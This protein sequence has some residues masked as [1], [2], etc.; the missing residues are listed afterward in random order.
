MPSVTRL[1]ASAPYA[2]PMGMLNR[3]FLTGN[4]PLELCVQYSHDSWLVVV[5]Y[6]VS[7]FAAY[8]AFHLIARVRATASG[9]ARFLWLATAGVSMGLG[10][11]AMHFIAMLAVEIPIQVRFDLPVTALSAGFAVVASTLAFHFVARDKPRAIELGIAGAVLGSG[12]G[13]MHYVGMAALRMPA[14]IYF[15]PL[16]FALSVVLAVMLSTAALVVLSALP[17]L[18]ND[19]FPLARLAGAAVMG[20]AIVMMHYTG[21]LATYFYPE[22]GTGDTGTLFDPSVMATAIAFVTLSIGGL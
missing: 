10:I 11:W 4:I 3:W 19:R 14:H 21:M 1:Q 15:D 18:H 5:S 9:P 13:L 7:G 6:L 8:T 12:I 2:A 22:P 16:L 20:L 17:Q